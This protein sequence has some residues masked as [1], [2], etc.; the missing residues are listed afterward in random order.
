MKLVQKYFFLLLLFSLANTSFAQTHAQ[1]FKK[2]CYVPLYDTRLHQNLSFQAPEP[3]I[4]NRNRSLIEMISSNTLRADFIEKYEKEIGPIQS[5][6][7][8]EEF[9]FNTSSWG[10]NYEKY[11]DQDS[12]ESKKLQ[13]VGDYV[14]RRQIEYEVDTSLKKNIRTRDV[15]KAK[16][17]LTKAE[18]E[19]A[20][21]V[22]LKSKYLISGNFIR[23]S[24]STPYINLKWLWELEGV[25]KQKEHIV[26]YEHTF[27]KKYKFKSQYKFLNGIID[28]EF[29]Y[30]LSRKMSNSVVL[31]SHTKSIEPKINNHNEHKILYIVSYSLN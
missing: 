20:G 10:D 24:I 19:L 3:I 9:Y 11:F 15:F 28:L 29:R 27:Q 6:Y 21:K 2:L 1:I 25:F 23:T 8:T 12:D 26:R 31:T 14:V 30:P 22:K 17:R 13:I 4:K 18:V 16:E 5:S 7:F